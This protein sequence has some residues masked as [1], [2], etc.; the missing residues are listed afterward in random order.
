MLRACHGAG[1]L[2]R[3]GPTGPRYGRDGRSFHPPSSAGSCQAVRFQ[4]RRRRTGSDRTAAAGAAH[5]AAGIELLRTRRGLTRTPLSFSTVVQRA[6][7]EHGR[8]AAGA[9]ESPPTEPPEDLACPAGG[10]GLTSEDLRSQAGAASSFAL[11]AILAAWN[12]VEGD[13]APCTG[14]IQR[15]RRQASSPRRPRA[16]GR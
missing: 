3:S 7:I 15:L 10:S 16:R 4:R 11:N 8:L 13:A 9:E 12:G 6:R 2:P 5:D 1:V 14:M